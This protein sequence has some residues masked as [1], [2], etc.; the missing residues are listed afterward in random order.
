MDWKREK[1]HH[2]SQCCQWL[3]WWKEEHNQEDKW[4]VLIGRRF[5]LV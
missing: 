5:E 4:Q 2:S 1:T 3:L